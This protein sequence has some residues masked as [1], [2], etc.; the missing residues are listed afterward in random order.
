MTA[1]RFERASLGRACLSKRRRRTMKV[2]TTL[3]IEQID[4]I[5]DEKKRVDAINQHLSEWF[6]AIVW[7]RSDAETDDDCV[8]L[9]K[10]ND[11]AAAD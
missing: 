8:H 9:I 4:A 6:N 7:P 1:F 5:K 11:D 3:T 10:T 2:R